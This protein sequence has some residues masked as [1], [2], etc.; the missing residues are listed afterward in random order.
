MSQANDPK[1]RNTC[2][3]QKL[4]VVPARLGHTRM[5]CPPVSVKLLKQLLLMLLERLGGGLASC[6]T[7]CHLMLSKGFGGK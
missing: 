2:A 1:V 7:L 6:C 3:C 4:D 5:E